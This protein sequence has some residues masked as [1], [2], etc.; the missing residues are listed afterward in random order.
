MKRLMQ[1]LRDWLCCPLCGSLGFNPECRECV[2]ADS[3]RRDL[4]P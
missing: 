2:D 4:Q 3:D 1:A